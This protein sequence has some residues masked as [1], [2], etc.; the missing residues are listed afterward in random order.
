VQLK[1]YRTFFLNAIG[2]SQSFYNKQ[3]NVRE[4]NTGL[5]V[6]DL[7]RGININGKDESKLRG[8]GVRRKPESVQLQYRRLIFPTTIQEGYNNI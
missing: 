2:I 7:K 5:T 3:T 6:D 1:L 8:E 4:E